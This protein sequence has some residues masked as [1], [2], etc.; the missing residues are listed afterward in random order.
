M[1]TV[2]ITGGRGFIGRNLTEKL[3]AEGYRILAPSSTELNLFDEQAVDAFMHRQPVDIIIHAANKGGGRDTTGMA[4]V[5][6]MNLRMFFN[7]VKHADRVE[8]ILHFGSGAEY[9]KHKP[10]V[11]AVEDDADKAMPLDDYGFY[12]AVCSRYIR[13]N[14]GNIIN[15]RIFGCY[16]KYEDYR[17]KFISNAIVKN[18]LGIP[19]II[20]QNVLFDYVYID[21]LVNM[22]IWAITCNPKYKE[23]NISRGAEID[24]VSLAQMVNVV[25]LKPSEIIVLEAGM[26]NEYTSSNSRILQEYAFEYMSYERA[27]AFMYKYYSDNLNIID[28]NAVKDDV[29]IK[30]ISTR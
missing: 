10:I 28:V 1:K 13:R 3:I 27:V 16:G 19:I 30:S 20:K 14:N 15:L 9:G 6:H 7:I 26:N 4:D 25:S 2:F 12:K 23:Y 24:L 22:V 21:D 17:Y 5:V 18:I 29:F 8:K 11:K